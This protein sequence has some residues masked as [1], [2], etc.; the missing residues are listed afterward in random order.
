MRIHGSRGFFVNVAWA[1]ESRRKTKK[2]KAQ[3]IG[4][5]SRG[6]CVKKAGPIVLDSRLSCRYALITLCA[7]RFADSCGCKNTFKIPA[8]SAGQANCL[9]IKLKALGRQ[10]K[11]S[12][13]GTI[14]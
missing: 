10:E 3:T 9:G 11:S 2:E 1:V 4:H 13:D 12:S 6:L 7:R 5:S 14:F 8:T